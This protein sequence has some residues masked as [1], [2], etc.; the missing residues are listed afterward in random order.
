MMKQQSERRTERAVT[1]LLQTLMRNLDDT[2]II[3]D[4]FEATHNDAELCC[5]RPYNALVTGHFAMEETIE[6][7]NSQLNKKR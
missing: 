1:L 6:K 7:I 5:S 4:E 2:G 3:L